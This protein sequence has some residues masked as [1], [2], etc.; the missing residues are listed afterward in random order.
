MPG[1]CLE[2]EQPCV[3]ANSAMWAAWGPLKLGLCIWCKAR[4]EHV[5]VLFLFI[6]LFLIS[7]K[8]AQCEKLYL[9]G[10]WH[11][12]RQYWGDIFWVVLL[13]ICSMDDLGP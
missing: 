11:I 13:A 4:T 7:L 8:L 2:T 12:Y 9:A 10:C 1:T 3:R 5:F 6:C